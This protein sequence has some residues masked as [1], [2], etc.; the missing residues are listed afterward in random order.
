MMHVSGKRAQ[1]KEGWHVLEGDWCVILGNGC[2][3]VNVWWG[4]SDIRIYMW[5]GMRTAEF[6]GIV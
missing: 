4:V 6:G 1:F 5:L 3:G 2:G